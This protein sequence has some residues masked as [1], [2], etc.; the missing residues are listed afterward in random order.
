MPA[1]IPN[2]FNFG[3]VAVRP[4]GMSYTRRR[5]TIA[6]SQTIKPGDIL[7]KT[8]GADTFEQFIALPTAGTTT[9]DGGT[10]KPVGVA[11]GAIT[12]NSSG[13]DVNQGN[14]T[15][16]EVAIWDQTI[17]VQLPIIAQGTATANTAITLS[18]VAA[19]SEPQDLAYVTLWRIGRY[20]TTSDGSSYFISSNSTNGCIAKV[21]VL[22]GDANIA[23]DFW[24]IFTRLAVAEANATL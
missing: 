19:N 18:S 15:T 20:N 14:A 4:K 22:G 17:E 9:L 8:S 5:L 11:L 6:A 24:P 16:V 2:S 3:A 21:G 13:I 12:T 7:G 10:A 23:V 1:L